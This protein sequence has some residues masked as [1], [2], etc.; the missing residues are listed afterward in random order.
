MPMAFRSEARRSAVRARIAALGYGVRMPD[1]QDYADLGTLL[2][3]PES[4]TA[5]QA[6]TVQGM[7]RSQEA[8]IA[9]WNV[10]DTRRVAAMSAVIAQ[11]DEAI[12]SMARQALGAVP[13]RYDQVA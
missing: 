1:D 7:R 5:E 2:A 4:W 12:S 9:A 6:E 3:D 10:K 13:A 8:A 11:M